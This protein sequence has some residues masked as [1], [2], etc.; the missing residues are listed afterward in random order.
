M[1]LV[2]QAIRLLLPACVLL[3]PD[4]GLK[5][6]TNHTLRI[7]PTYARGG[8]A[9][10]FFDEIS[11]VPLETT[12][13]SS[14][15]I[16]QNIQVSEHYIA[17]A[18]ISTSTLF[19]FKKDGHFHS[20]ITELPSMSRATRGFFQALS[21]F[22]LQPG[23]ENISIVYGGRD[24]TG[25]RHLAVFSADGKLIHSKQLNTSF[26]NLSGKFSPLNGNKALFATD[27]KDTPAYFDVVG[28]MDVLIGER[29]QKKAGDPFN[30]SWMNSYR[31]E[32]S[33][34][35]GSIWS[36][37]YDNLF[38]HFDSQGNPST[39]TILLPASLALSSE[40]YE[41]SSI[42]GNEKNCM[43]YLADHRNKISTIGELYKIRNIIGFTFTKYNSSG[44]LDSYWYS[45]TTQSLYCAGKVSTDTMCYSLPIFA[46]PSIVGTDGDY[47]YLNAPSFVLF[48]AVANLPD[49]HWQTNPILNT[50]F[51]TENNKS[52]PVLI[53]LKFKKNL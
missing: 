23:S 45:L 21:G 30:K 46:L 12:K 11:F 4:L 51:T 47:I 42:I 10:Q 44:P 31:L 14:F 37:P 53:R 2:Y 41:D 35:E 18:D 52:N 49:K 13:E 24:K 8:K 43:E 20:K 33:S 26:N 15:G 1:I 38:Y 36:R 16:L 27:N 34:V 29:V 9:S 5:A 3:L 6:Q 28:D 40:F 7:D 22:I 39:Y 50:Y 17:F 48:N 19:V 32:S 25:S